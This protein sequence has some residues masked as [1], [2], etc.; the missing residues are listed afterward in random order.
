M[1]KLLEKWYTPTQKEL[2]AIFYDLFFRNIMGTLKNPLYNRTAKEALIT[3]IRQ[4][5]IVYRQGVFTGEFNIETSRALSKFATFDGRSR[6]WK[7]Q[8]PVDV[9]AAATVANRRAEQLHADINRE[10]TRI[11][12]QLQ[13]VELTYQFP[14]PGPVDEMDQQLLKD[15]ASIGI[16]PELSREMQ[17]NI[18]RDYNQN[19]NLNIKNWVPDQI[20]RLRDMV[21]LSV[22]KGYRR[23]DMIEM[24]MH[25][26][27]VTK[28][29]AK[30]LARQETSLL[31]S[32]LRK[33]RSL[34]AGIRKYRWS[35]SLDRKV[36]PEDAAAARTGANHRYLHGQIFEY[37]NPPVVN[38][39]T[40]KRAEP[41]QDFQ[42]RCVAIPVL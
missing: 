33:E 31:M 12:D 37:G 17:K 7:G 6:T 3:K 42:C 41:G 26:W 24:I 4:G 25:E 22:S 38:V 1:L 34:D 23:P 5:K 36:R 27:G 15:F 14:I 16:Q 13:D 10:I 21:E 29:K 2:E 30:F 32:T 19:Q 11:E 18:I 8:P 40:G 20:T 9:L 28:N 35:T 39:K